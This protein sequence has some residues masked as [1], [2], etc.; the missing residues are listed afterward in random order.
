VKNDLDPL[1]ALH[2][3]CADK[4]RPVVDRRS[5]PYQVVGHQ[6]KIETQEYIFKPYE[7]MHFIQWITNVLRFAVPAKNIYRSVSPNLAL[8][9]FRW[10][11]GVVEAGRTQIYGFPDLCC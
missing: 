2:L 3:R 7:V 6:M 8:S 11:H 1:K 5:W 10:L 9:S 4:V